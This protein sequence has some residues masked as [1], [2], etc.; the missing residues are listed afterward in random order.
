[1]S[2]LI[3]EYG[4]N[5]KKLYGDEYENLRYSSDDPSIYQ[6]CSDKVQ[7]ETLETSGTAQL[8]WAVLQ[9]NEYQIPYTLDEY[10]QMI[11]DYMVKYPTINEKPTI[12]ISIAVLT[13]TGIRCCLIHPGLSQMVPRTMVSGSWMRTRRKYIINMQRM[14]RKNIMN[15]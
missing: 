12:G 13:G 10:T 4:P 15:G 6:L 3:D 1:M 2:D 8:Q 9:E 14:D 11:R 7:E 5:I